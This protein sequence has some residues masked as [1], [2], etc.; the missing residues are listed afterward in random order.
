MSSKSKL[1]VAGL[2]MIAVGSISTVAWFNTYTFIIGSLLVGGGI[3]LILLLGTIDVA[4]WGSDVVDGFDDQNP[5]YTHES[6]LT[7]DEDG[8][9]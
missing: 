5:K 3:A 2:G 6:K 8:R 1:A 9:K 4:K 7:W